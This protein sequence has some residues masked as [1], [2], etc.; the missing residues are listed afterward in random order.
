MTPSIFIGL[1]AITIIITF[2]V[3]AI[4]LN[5]FDKKKEDKND[6]SE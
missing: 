1:F 5:I 6:K 3:G 2:A 4:A